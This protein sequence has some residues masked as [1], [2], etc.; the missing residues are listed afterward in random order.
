[1]FNF[2]HRE[3]LLLLFIL[4]LLIGLYLLYHF[5]RK[6]DIKKI[7]NPEVVAFPDARLFIFQEQSEILFCCC[8]PWL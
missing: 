2:E 6:R 1:M 8:C 5:S 7:G 3:Y 4:P